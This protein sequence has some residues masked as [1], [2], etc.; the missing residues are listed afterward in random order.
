METLVFFGKLISAYLEKAFSSLGTASTLLNSM[1]LN[2]TSAYAKMTLLAGS[3]ST[4]GDALLSSMQTIGLLFLIIFFA[5]DLMSKVN[6]INFTLEIFIRS[7]GRLIIGYALMSYIGPICDGI[8]EFGNLLASSMTSMAVSFDYGFDNPHLMLKY[9]IDDEINLTFMQYINIF[10]KAIIQILITALLNLTAI[11]L[12]YNR[13]IKLTIYKIFMPIMVADV[14][15]SGVSGR[16]LA[17]IKKYLSI[18]MEYPICCIIA[19]LTGVLINATDTTTVNWLGYVG[20]LVMIGYAI[21]K[22]MKSISTESEE[23]FSSR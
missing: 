19:I 20:Q 7:L 14:Y 5:V 17:H 12:A 10:T 6:S 2:F 16:P 21:F 13:A 23:I 8:V 1:E 22:V 15:G 9:L 3:G 18:V 4:V 11:V